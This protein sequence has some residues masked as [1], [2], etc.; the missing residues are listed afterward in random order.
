MKKKLGMLNVGYVKR[1]IE[2]MLSPKMVIRGA[3]AFNVKME[4]PLEDEEVNT[5]YWYHLWWRHVESRVGNFDENKNGKDISQLE[6]KKRKQGEEKMDS[7]LRR[8]YYLASLKG[9][10]H[11]Q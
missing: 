7:T 1:T 3:S 5:A 10:W 8:T 11:R 4:R 6:N 9:K 2:E